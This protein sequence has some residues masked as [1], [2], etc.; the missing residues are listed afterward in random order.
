MLTLVI[1]KDA[2]IKYSTDP[3]KYLPVVFTRWEGVE[4]MNYSP[5]IYAYEQENIAVTGEGLLDGSG[6]NENWWI[7]DG[8]KEYGWE[9]GIPNQKE[10]R[11]K[12]FEMGE[13]NIPVQKCFG[14]RCNFQ[15]FANVVFKS[16]TLYKCNN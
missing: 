3:K 11:K 15:K 7:W 5:L 1:C 10:G 2:I 12:L 4:C 13:Q 9:N 14:R 8:K 6:S 16:R